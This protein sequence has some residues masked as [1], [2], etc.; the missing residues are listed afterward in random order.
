MS[1]YSKDLYLKKWFLLLPLKPSFSSVS[2]LDSPLLARRRRTGTTRES[3][4]LSALLGLFFPVLLLLQLFLSR[5]RG[6]AEDSLHRLE[7]EGGGGP[8]E[9]GSNFPSPIVGKNNSSSCQTCECLVHYWASCVRSTIR[10]S[11]RSYLL[12]RTL[13]G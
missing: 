1:F 5:R 12:T 10:T 4:H 7:A 2:G 11:R 9:G 13:V 3:R 6:R 8:E